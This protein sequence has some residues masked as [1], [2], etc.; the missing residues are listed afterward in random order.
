MDTSIQAIIRSLE[1]PESLTDAQLYEVTANAQAAIKA[2]QDEYL[3]L[4]KEVRAVAPS[5]APKKPNRLRKVQDPAE[6]ERQRSRKGWELTHGDRA[7]TRAGTSNAVQ[8]AG[9]GAPIT[10]QEALMLPP[11]SRDPGIKPYATKPKSVYKGYPLAIDMANTFSIAPHDGKRT[12]KP[13]KVFEGGDEPTLILEES[14]PAPIKPRKRSRTEEK[15]EW[16]GDLPPPP[17]KRATSGKSA[18]KI[19]SPPPLTSNA[20]ERPRN[21]DADADDNIAQPAPKKRATNSKLE[22]K[23]YLAPPLAPSA[24]HPAPPPLTS[25]KGKRPRDIDADDDDDTAEPALQKRATSSKLEKKARSAPT[26]PLLAPHPAPPSS[27]IGQDP[28]TKE[29]SISSNTLP[30]PPPS[31]PSASPALQVRRAASTKRTHSTASTA[32]TRIKNQNRSEAMKAAWKKR[33]DA[34]TNGRRGG[35]PL[36]STITKKMKREE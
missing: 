14:P 33:Q 31:P 27:Q 22:K 12:R 21:T 36:Q 15:D 18:S 24:P 17:K 16:A 3:Q 1:H 35:A 7:T 11:T 29:V 13:R 32:T 4:E 2:M 28:A 10:A 34:G 5:L 20:G 6:Y 23:P 9:Q 26:L 8:T 19:L 30:Q 25:K